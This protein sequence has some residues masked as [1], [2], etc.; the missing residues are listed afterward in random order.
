MKEQVIKILHFLC[1][2]PVQ[3]NNIRGCWRIHKT[4]WEDL[5]TYPPVYKRKEGSIPCGS[6]NISSEYFWFVALSFPKILLRISTNSNQT[7]TVPQIHHFNLGADQP[8]LD[9]V[10]IQLFYQISQKLFV[11]KTLH[12]KD[13]VHHFHRKPQRTHKFSLLSMIEREVD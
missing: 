9:K 4:G 1:F 5:N 7:N 13:I 3:P 2:L 10:P 6:K 12:M 11:I 8:I